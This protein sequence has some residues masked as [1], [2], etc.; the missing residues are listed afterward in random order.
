MVK[1]REIFYKKHSCKGFSFIHAFHISSHS[2]K[3]PHHILAENRS[4]A[5]KMFEG[6]HELNTPLTSPPSS[7][8]ILRPLSA[9]P[10][11]TAPPTARNTAL[12]CIK[13]WMYW[14]NTSFSDRSRRFSSLT[15][16]TRVVKSSNV[17]CSSKTYAEHKENMIIL[18][19]FFINKNGFFW[20]FLSLRVCLIRAMNVEKAV[21]VILKHL[22]SALSSF[23]EVLHVEHALYVYAL[24]LGFFFTH[25]VLFSTL[26]TKK[27]T[28]LFG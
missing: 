16:S 6:Y 4:F 18:K 22:V 21:H 20:L 28:K 10:E 15:P 23:M 19:I 13:L 17:F 27:Q 26:T 1:I 8:S 9:S 7:S 11:A 14:P 12:A 5:G 25:D 3:L 24:L 2:K